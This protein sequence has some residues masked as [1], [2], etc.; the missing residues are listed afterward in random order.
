MRSGCLPRRHQA[1]C[2]GI[3][4][5]QF[6][7]F[8]HPCVCECQTVFAFTFFGKLIES[9][10]FQ[11]WR[12]SAVTPRKKFW[13]QICVPLDRVG[14]HGS[15]A[16]PRRNKLQPIASV[17]SINALIRLHIGPWLH[18]CSESS[19]MPP[20]LVLRYEYIWTDCFAG[21]VGF[22]GFSESN[23]RAK[24][25]PCL[26]D[27]DFNAHHCIGSRTL[28]RFGSTIWSGYSCFVVDGCIYSCHQIRKGMVTRSL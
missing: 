21:T 26:N 27:D 3:G 2:I 25:S 7:R 1:P 4:R 15:L 5:P 28:L 22:R 10:R 6:E 17:Y 20:M 19:K 18:D 23:S 24:R 12:P 8:C 13:V 14:E 11:G 9:S 16:M